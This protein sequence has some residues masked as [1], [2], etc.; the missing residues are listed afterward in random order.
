MMLSLSR[1]SKNFGR[2]VLLGRYTACSIL[3]AGLTCPAMASPLHFLAYGKFDDGGSFY[4]TFALE[5]STMTFADVSFHSGEGRQFRP[6]EYQTVNIIDDKNLSL[7]LDVELRRVLTLYF[8]DELLAG[9]SPIE[10]DEFELG[11]GFRLLAEARAILIPA[12]IMKPAGQP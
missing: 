3:A 9:A 12:P 2:L 10:G 8:S 4:G 6:F 5:P 1:L 7:T 11:L